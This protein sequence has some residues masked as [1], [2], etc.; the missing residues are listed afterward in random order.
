MATQQPMKAA[1][2]KDLHVISH[3]EFCYW[4]FTSL[5]HLESFENNGKHIALFILFVSS[6]Y[7]TL[8]FRLRLGLDNSVCA[9]IIFIDQ[10]FFLRL[11]EE[12]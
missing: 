11:A 12:S 4:S 1:T 3:C 7:I 10:I 5:E 6:S 9:C 8:P 2:C